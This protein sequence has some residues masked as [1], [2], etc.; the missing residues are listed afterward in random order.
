MPLGN[1]PVTIV[2]TL[3]GDPEIRAVGSGSVASFSVAVTPRKK[4]GD[5]WVDGETTWF[6]C[7]AWAGLGEHAAGSLHKG[8][9]VLISGTIGERKYTDKDGNERSSWEVEVDE[10]GPSLRFATALVTRIPAGGRGRQ[11]APQRPQR[12]EPQQTWVG[13]D[14]Y[15]DQ[16]F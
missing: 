8:D 13:P 6:R 4:D 11:A 10:M 7:S 16:P 5:A 14:A 2:G 9:R 1:A 12:A 15:D 3:G